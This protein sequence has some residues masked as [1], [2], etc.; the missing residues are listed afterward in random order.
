MYI[1]LFKNS[2]G[3]FPKEG[4][5]V[6]LVKIHTLYVKHQKNMIIQLNLFLTYNPFYN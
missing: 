1:V 4:N 5:L 6:L 2:I 3:V